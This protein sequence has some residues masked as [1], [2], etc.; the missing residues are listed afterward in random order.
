MGSLRVLPGHDQGRDAGEKGRKEC[1]RGLHLGEID[2]TVVCSRVRLRYLQRKKGEAY[3]IAVLSGNS[4]SK[5]NKFS[6]LPQTGA[7]P[8]RSA[9]RSTEKV[10]VK[11]T[12]MDGLPTITGQIPHWAGRPCQREY[13]GTLWGTSRSPDLP[14]MGA[15]HSR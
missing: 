6:P 15:T 13:C 10:L 1:Q 2:S 11:E 9:N 12:R 5:L 8:D 4:W 7:G 3:F 14:I